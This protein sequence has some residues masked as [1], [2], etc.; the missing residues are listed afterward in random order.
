MVTRKNA[1]KSVPFGKCCR[2]N[3]FVFWAVAREV[4]PVSATENEGCVHRR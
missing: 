4:E 3:P 1:L 2:S